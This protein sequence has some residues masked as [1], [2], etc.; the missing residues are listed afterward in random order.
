MSSYLRMVQ[1]PGVQGSS[2]LYRSHP[3][4]LN[5][6]RFLKLRLKLPGI[7]P[8]WMNSPSPAPLPSLF[9]AIIKVQLTSPT[10]LSLVVVPNTLPLAIISFGSVL[11]PAHFISIGCHLHSSQLIPSPSLFPLMTLRVIGPLLVSSLTA[12]RR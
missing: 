12:R 5:I 8:S 1:S 2:E 7:T 11:N 3:L 10:I 4:K 9:M 6:S